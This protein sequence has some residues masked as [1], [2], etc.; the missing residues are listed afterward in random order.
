LREELVAF[1]AEKNRKGTRLR[2]GGIRICCWI[3]RTDTD[4]YQS[5]RSRGRNRRSR[6]RAAAATQQ[7]RRHHESQHRCDN[8][9]S[10][11]PHQASSYAVAAPPLS[12]KACVE[13]ASGDHAP[14]A[15]RMEIERVNGREKRRAPKKKNGGHRRRGEAPRCPPVHGPPCG[16]HHSGCWEEVATEVRCAITNQ[17]ARE[18]FDDDRARIIQMP[19]RTWPMTASRRRRDALQRKKRGGD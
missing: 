4:R 2:A 18:R 1:R 8:Q 15:G 14:G 3:L 6:A 5:Y 7:Q 12:S 17:S 16:E 11:P 19:L 13:F 10:R 9:T